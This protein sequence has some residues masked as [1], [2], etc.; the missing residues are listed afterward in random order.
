MAITTKAELDKLAK[1]AKSKTKATTTETK[2]I[3]KPAAKI[4][5]PKPSYSL[6]AIRG[7]Q[8]GREYYVCMV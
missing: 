3:A 1:V 7:I 2:V 5:Q 8:A 4:Q 6:P